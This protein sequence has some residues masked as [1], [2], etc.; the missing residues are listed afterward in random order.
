MQ[1]V[2]IFDSLKDFLLWLSP[3]IFFVGVFL[4]FAPGMYRKLEEKLGQEIGGIKK[5]VAPKLE[6]NIFTFHNW[7]LSRNTVFGLLFV[8]SALVFYIVLR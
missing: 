1:E 8:V 6:T 5:R 2:T 7:L 3:V 4:L